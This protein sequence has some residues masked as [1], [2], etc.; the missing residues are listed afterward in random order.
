MAHDLADELL[1]DLGLLDELLGDTVRAQSGEAALALVEGLEGDALRLRSGELAG[2]RDRFASRFA[3]L[4]LDGLPLVGRAFTLLFHLFNAAEE[5]HRIRVLRR[6]DRSHAPPDG[7]LAAACGEL[8][9]AGVSADDM[10]ALLG[11]LF[12]MPVLTAHPT[13]ARRR[14]VIELLAQV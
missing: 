3:E 6:R 8:A 1:R 9:A 2:G 7:S 11:R 14:T 13:E 12:V 10:R 4:D 5:Q